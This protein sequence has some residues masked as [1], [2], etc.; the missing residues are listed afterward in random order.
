MT[1]QPGLRP[2]LGLFSSTM[3]ALSI[4]I[5][6]GMLV[7]PGL[8]YRTVGPGA[9]WSWLGDA[10]LVIPLLWVFIRLGRLYPSAGGVSGFVGAVWPRA[11]K[12]VATILLGTFALGIPAIALT[13]SNYLLA[14]AGWP[15]ATPWSELVALLLMGAATAVVWLGAALA[16]RWQ[17]LVLAALL[18][19]LLS[20]TL[21]TA[22]DWGSARLVLGPDRIP[23]VWR[24]MALAFFSYTGWEMF[25]SIAEDMKDPRRDFPRA[26]LI[27][28]VLITII[29]LSA[30]L[31]VETTVAL[32]NPYLVKA[33]FL[34][35]VLHLVGDQGLARRLLGGIVAIIIFS[36]LVGAI[37]AASRIVFD[38]GRTTALG[39]RLNLGAVHQE[40]SSPRRAVTVAFLAFAAIL[41]SHGAGLLS[42]SR[43]LWLA[44]QNFIVLYAV[45]VLVFFRMAQRRRERVVALLSL[46]LMAVLGS[47]FNLGLIYPCALFSLPYLLLPL[48]SRKGAGRLDRV[49]P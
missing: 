34:P 9:F 3:L 36:N 17:N 42:V 30:A 13:G 16:S 47:A 33:P 12:G 7:L 11:R 24:G 44:G 43:M 21:A 25:A 35:V 18:A 27:S 28:F 48:G 46:G 41:A 8:V 20:A 15:S 19:V 32:D 22:P 10:L 6:A 26:V 23:A 2:T 37:W 1:N 5:G 31:A 39:T 49:P 14:G 40:S 4:V 29:Y 45:C 38:L